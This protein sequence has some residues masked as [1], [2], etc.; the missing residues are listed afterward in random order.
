MKSK[1]SLK[2]LVG[3]L[4]FSSTV[5]V[6]AKK[7]GEKTSKLAVVNSFKVSD[8]LKF[9]KKMKEVKNMNGMSNPILQRLFK[10]IRQNKVLKNY[11]KKNRIYTAD[12]ISKNLKN[13]VR[14]AMIGKKKLID[15]NKEKIKN[16]NKEEIKEEF[17]N[18]MRKSIEYLKQVLSGKVKLGE[19][20]RLSK[21]QLIDQIDRI[22]D[23]IK[24]CDG[25]IFR[26]YKSGMPKYLKISLAQHE[27]DME[28][29]KELSKSEAS[30]SF[31]EGMLG[32]FFNN[33]KNFGQTIKEMVK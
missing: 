19:N 24:N 21:T 27:K 11:I 5:S 20:V 8:L 6:F 23:A 2:I 9:S 28:D 31:V 17:R 22:R 4:I 33:N 10:E 18:D 12:K 26:E 29:L 30:L 7:K 25:E 16:M 1:I 3:L 32:A 14:R 15:E 13:I